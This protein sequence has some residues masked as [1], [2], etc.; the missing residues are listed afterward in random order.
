MK[1]ESKQLRRVSI[2]L[3]FL[4][5]MALSVIS[6]CGPSGPGSP[7]QKP[8][9][10]PTA[11]PIILTVPEAVELAGEYPFRTLLE[12]AESKLN[13]AFFKK[14]SV[15]A[16]K[17]GTHYG[18][19]GLAKQELAEHGFDMRT[20]LLGDRIYTTACFLA[21]S[22]GFELT[23]TGDQLN[24]AKGSVSFTF[25]VGSD[26]VDFGTEQLP[27]YPPQRSGNHVFIDCES[28]ARVTGQESYFDAEKGIFLMYPADIDPDVNEQIALYEARYELY[29]RVVYNIDNVECD[30]TGSGLYEPV[31]FGERQVGIA[32][33]TWHRAS[34]TWN[35]S[36]KWDIPLIGGYRSENKEVIYQHG[37]WL[38]DAG[39]DF[40]FVDWSNDV[41]YDPAT[42][43]SSRDDFRTIEEATEDLFEVWSTIPDAPKIC[44]FNGPGHVQQKEDTF[45]NGR[46]KA[47][48]DQI[49][50]TFIANEEF[51]KMYYYY[52]GK[53][54]MPCYSATPSF[55]STDDVYTDDRFTIR[56]VTGYVGQQRSLF[57]AETLVSRFHWSWE[58]RG[59]QT[60]TV[61]NGQPE[62]MTVVASWRKQSKE[63]QPGYIAP[64]LRN[65]GATFRLQWARADLIGVKIVLVVSFNEW[66]LGEQISL[67]N[68]KDIE[69]SQTYG[70]LYLD[71]MKEQIK[72]FK[73]KTEEYV[74]R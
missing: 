38:R 30:T 34:S 4:A 56:W 49:Y 50:D 2:S 63:G 29:E 12:G 48:C 66:S 42:M 14:G 1:R 11:E 19:Y 39:V 10:V 40:V 41:N 3:F 74:N 36:S 15:T 59:A 9:A 44:I 28:F 51:N 37:I 26:K 25:T 46:M 64:G 54:L 58:E 69:P 67:E 5:L 31:A 52:D 20:T 17:T 43:R 16:V 23:E 53:P 8:T 61:F 71:I 47:K 22:M 70:T 73:G 72:K 62:A 55:N 7:A 33:T 24:F 65:D 18:F 35:T 45:A 32:Y 21:G 6:G 27:V 13:K 60:F 57:D 68:S